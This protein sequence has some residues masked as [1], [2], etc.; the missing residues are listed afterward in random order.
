MLPNHQ[1]QIILSVSYQHSVYIFYFTCNLSNNTPLHFTNES[2]C[3]LVHYCGN[4]KLCPAVLRKY[5]L[6]IYHIKALRILHVSIKSLL[7][8][9]NSNEFMSNQ[10][11]VS[12]KISASPQNLTIFS[13]LLFP[14]IQ[15]PIMHVLPTV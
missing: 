2:T 14:K 15:K 13:E 4:L 9:L 5:P 7:I 10:L 12:W 6:R 11:D 8:L 3:N 1:S